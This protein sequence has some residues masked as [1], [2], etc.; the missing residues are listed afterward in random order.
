MHVKRSGKQETEQFLQLAKFE[1]LSLKLT[2]WRWEGYFGSMQ[3]G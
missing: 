3:K 1:L 2:A